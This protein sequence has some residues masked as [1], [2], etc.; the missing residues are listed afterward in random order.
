MLD[1]P[2]TDFLDE[3]V[4]GAAARAEGSRGKEYTYSV[5]LMQSFIRVI[6][7]LGVFPA[8]WHTAFEGLPLESRLPVEVAHQVLEAVVQ[9]TSDVDVGLKAAREWGPGDGGALDY[10]ISSAI[11]IRDALD[12]GSRYIALVNDALALR[13]TTRGADA[14]VRL[15]NRVPLPRAA[16]DF[17]VGA[18]YRAF[19]SVWASGARSTLRVLIEHAAPADT[20]E[21]ARTFDGAPIEFGAPFSGFVFDAALLDTRL[22]GAELR[23]NEVIRRHAETMLQEL[24]CPGELTLRVRGAITEE[25]A[26]G[27]PSVGHIARRLHMSARTLERK[28]AREGT[29]FSVLMEE[30]RRQLA[31]RYVASAE[32]ELA[33]I[34][35]RLGFSHT[36]AF[37]RAF[38]RWTGDT[39]LDYRR[40]QRPRLRLA[41]APQRRAG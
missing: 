33:E 15:E 18:L 22:P 35:F 19:R 26:D 27:D 38:K 21:Y 7:P 39:P 36:T 34:A 12:A 24:A 17:Q 5:R 13:V 41:E 2:S 16:R 31:V 29:T 28:L 6:G 1:V 8:E 4:S 23:L 20:T 30:L 9:L 11:T 37:H 3:P 32:L 25:L 40:A 14:L 10:A